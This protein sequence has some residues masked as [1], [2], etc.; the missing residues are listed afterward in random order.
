MSWFGIECEKCG[1]TWSDKRKPYGERIDY[2]GTGIVGAWC[3][4]CAE[5]WFEYADARKYDVSY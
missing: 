3:I 4:D 2:M 5:R 1:R